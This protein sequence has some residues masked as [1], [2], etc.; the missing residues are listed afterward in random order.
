MRRSEILIVVGIIALA[1]FLRVWQLGSAPPGL[2][3][4]EAMNGNNALEALKTGEWKVFYPENNGREG[5][6]IGIQAAVLK[7]AGVNEPW[8]LRLPSAIFGSLTVMGVFFLIFELARLSRLASPFF[9]ASAGSLFLA[10]SHWHLIFS[11]IGFRAIMAPF[12][13]VW[14]VYFFAVALRS[15]KFRYAAL[16][17]ISLGA[18]AYSYIA[19]RVMPLVF[20]V[21]IPVFLKK[22]GFWH[23]ALGA[24][25]A[26]IIVIIPLGFYFYSHPADFLGRTSQVS[27]FNSDTPTTDLFR[28]IAKTVVMLNFRGDTNWR[29][30]FSGG[31]QLFLPVG[32]LFWVGLAAALRRRS[33][34]D[35]VNFF[36]LIL[37]MLPV[38]VSNEGL[39]HA[40]R[41]IIMI[42][43]VFAL[44][45]AGSAWSWRWAR[46][47]LSR[48]QASTV[49]G[50]IVLAAFL[51]TYV[52]Y[53]EIWANHPE[54]TKAFAAEYVKVGREIN[55]LPPETE[56][57]VV[58]EASGVDVRGLPMPVQ[59]V[60]FITDSFLTEESA[61][62]NIHYLTAAQYDLR[63][64][65]LAGK[66]VFVIR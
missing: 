62:K 40:L 11:R 8:A 7:L 64:S 25:L 66:S 29:H 43:P 10:M 45:G 60:M 51:Y 61:K 12:F 65:E 27:V 50:V 32:I 38:V 28:N 36:W 21:F 22:R 57:Y 44:V 42:P 31:P 53:F 4:D 56:K 15:H 19:Y 26:A 55:A 13:L 20:A 3:P 35:A 5:L 1:F 47:H 46:E 33:F 2:Y 17:G 48:A 16:S 59:T 37:A 6:F 9:V 54:T 63:K 24:A 49:A 39:P 18:G 41:A 52:G 58:V 14:S 30:N 34:F 23:I